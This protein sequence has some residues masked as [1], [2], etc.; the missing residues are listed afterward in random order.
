[1]ITIELLREHLAQLIAERNR[2]AEEA[3]QQ[4]AAYNGAIQITER[5]IAQ[6]EADSTEE[7]DK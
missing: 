1:M 4:I 7:E 6:A 3:R 5:L 2:Y